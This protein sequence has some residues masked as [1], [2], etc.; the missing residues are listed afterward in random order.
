M[1]MTTKNDM[2]TALNYA[3]HAMREAGAKHYGDNPEHWELTTQH[4]GTGSGWSIVWRDTRNGGVSPL[5]HLGDNKKDVT[6]KSWD[7]VAVAD[8]IRRGA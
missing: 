2:L 8:A 1:T 6:R 3:V 5:V 7:I 4:M